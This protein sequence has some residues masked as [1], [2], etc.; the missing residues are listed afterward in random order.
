[1]RSFFLSFFLS[2]LLSFCQSLGIPTWF[3]FDAYLVFFDAYLVFFDAYL[4]FFKPLSPTRGAKQ[5]D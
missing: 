1:M 2:F 5:R 4:V 3:F